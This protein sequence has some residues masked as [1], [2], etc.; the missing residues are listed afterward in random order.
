MSSYTNNS[1]VCI[2]S[3]LSSPLKLLMKRLLKTVNSAVLHLQIEKILSKEYQRKEQK[4]KTLKSQGDIKQLHG[5][6][7]PCC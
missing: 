7:C 2:R 4:E 5:E 6:F 3:V 1:F